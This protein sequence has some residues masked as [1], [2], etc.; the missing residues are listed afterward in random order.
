M[1]AVGYDDKMAVK[2]ETC[3][4]EAKGAHLIRNSWGTECG[5]HGW[6]GWLPYEY[7][8]NGLAEDWWTLIKQ[9]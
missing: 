4:V 3:D 1:M 7:V 2:N 9:S 6:I 8:L 5:P